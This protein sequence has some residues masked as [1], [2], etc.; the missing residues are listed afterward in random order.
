GN[1]ARPPAPEADRG[2]RPGG[3]LPSPKPAAAAPTAG[4]K[5]ARASEQLAKL[6]SAESMDDSD[7]DGKDDGLAGIRALIKAVGGKTFVKRHDGVW[8]DKAWDGKATTTK[9]EAWSEAYFKLLERGD[10]VAKFL[11]LGEQLIVV[12][13]GTAFEVVPAK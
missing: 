2:G 5:K 9:V 1:G 8:V 7:K 6:K 3:A 10:K 4:E 13:D 12:L 11:A